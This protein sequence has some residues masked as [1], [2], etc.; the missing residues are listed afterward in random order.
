MAATNVQMADS[1]WERLRRYRE[2]L[3]F[4]AGEQWE[5][6]PRPGEKRLTFNYARVFVHKA[7]SYLFGKPYNLQVPPSDEMSPGACRRGGA[8]A[9][10]HLRGQQPLRARLR[11]RRRRRRHRRR[12]LPRP[13]HGGGRPG[14]L[15]RPPGA[16][17]RD[18]PAGLPA[19]ARRH[20]QLH[21][22]GAR[23]SR[24][25]GRPQALRRVRRALDRLRGHAAGRWRPRR[26]PAQPP[27]AYPLRHI[28]QHSQAV[29]LLGR[30]RPGGPHR[31]G[32]GAQQA[33]VRARLGAGGLGQPD[34]R[35]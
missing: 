28:P 23:R 33:H 15:R 7:A 29:L 25:V 2:Y 16:G 27:G 9:Q 35:T 30:I 8:P 32:A 13:P 21:R 20:P 18:R 6:P 14:H 3:D 11:H 4:Y 34:R 5:S 17:R 1:R 26:H 19:G 24:P 22:R 12:R 10:G 31:A